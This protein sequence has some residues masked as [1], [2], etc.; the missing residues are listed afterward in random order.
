MRFSPRDLLDFI[1]GSLQIKKLCAWG[2][3]NNYLPGKFTKPATI[4]PF[5]DDILWNT[6]RSGF[7]KT[8]FESTDEPAH[9]GNSP[10]LK[11][12]PSLRRPGGAGGAGG[13]FPASSPPSP[14][15]SSLKQACLFSERKRRRSQWELTEKQ[16]FAFDRGAL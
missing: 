8:P 13:A 11:T 6:R 16:Q 2:K 10:G 14:S 7:W 9:L 15:A 4:V 5:C 1:W 12:K 3:K